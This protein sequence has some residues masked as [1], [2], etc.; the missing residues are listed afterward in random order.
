M[1]EST[2]CPYCG[3]PV[4]EPRVLQS[5]ESINVRCY[6]C[7]RVFEYIPGFGTFSISDQDSGVTVSRGPTYQRM[8]EEGIPPPQQPSNCSG[9]CC[10]MVCVCLLMTMI[11]F[12]VFYLLGLFP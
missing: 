12:F 8:T 3:S 10:T 2:T 5:E 9:L 6:K 7:G 1:S 11:P 4:T